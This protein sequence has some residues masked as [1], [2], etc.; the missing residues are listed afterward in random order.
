MEVP[1][2]SIDA[3]RAWVIP[4]VESPAWPTVKVRRAGFSDGFRGPHILIPQGISEALLRAAYVEQA[5]SFQDSIQAIR[6]PKQDGARAKLLTAVLNSKLAAWFYFHTTASF[7][8]DRPKVHQ[9][10]VLELPFPEPDHLSHPKQAK[11]AARQIVE[12]LDALLARKD[13]VLLSEDWMRPYIER[14]NRLVYEYYGLS[15]EEV[16]IIEDCVK[17]IIPSVQPHRESHPPLF[18]D[19]TRDERFAYAQ[20]LV[21]VLT[22]WTDRDTHVS[23]RLWDGDLSW[24][25]IGL[26]IDGDSLPSTVA[27]ERQTSALRQTL[28]RV[29]AAVPRRQSRNLELEPNLKVFIDDSLY[30]VK[31]SGRRYWLRSTALNDADEVAGEMLRQQKRNMLL[32]GGQ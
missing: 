12:I 16:V 20:I 11:L 27:V 2:L 19:S 5:L 1:Y 31:P 21:D 4:A 17:T 10:Q 23:V 29:M 30:L 3:F 7:G 6:F 18:S 32:E 28:S 24:S 9:Q 25:V 15:D 13:E 8:A 14:A 22:R 26:Q